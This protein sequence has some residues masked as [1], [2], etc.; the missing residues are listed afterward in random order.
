[1]KSHNCAKITYGLSAKP[2]TRNEMRYISNM[3]FSVLCDKYQLHKK[4]PTFYK[5]VWA[6]QSSAGLKYPQDQTHNYNT[7]SAL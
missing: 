2:K 3:Q 4:D 7:A 5:L 1:M 6:V